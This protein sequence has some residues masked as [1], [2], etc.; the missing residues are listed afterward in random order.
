MGQHPQIPTLF[1]YFQA[2]LERGGQA[3]PYLY[4]AQEYVSGEN[5]LQALER[6]EVFGEDEIRNILE[7]MILLCL[8]TTETFSERQEVERSIK[9]YTHNLTHLDYSKPSNF[10]FFFRVPVRNPI[11][12][13]LCRSICPITC[14]ARSITVA[15]KPAKRPASIP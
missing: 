2:N 12:I 15:G 11:A 4:L 6:R 10:S 9:S 7:W 8:A 3:Y 13:L 14:L 1:A 5:L